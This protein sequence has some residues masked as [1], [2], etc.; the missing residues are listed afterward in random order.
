MNAD[1]YNIPLEGFVSANMRIVVFSGAGMSAESGLRTFRDN[2]GLWEEHSIYEVATPEA[3]ERDQ[4]LVLKFYNERRKQLLT[5]KPNAGHQALVKLEEHYDVHIVTQNIDDLH[6]RAGSSNVLHLH[7]ELR[8]ARSSGREDLVYEIEGWELKKGDCCDEGF[9]LRP[10]V[11]WFGEQVPMIP[12]AADIVA[13][14]DLLLVIGSSL[15]VYPAAGLVHAVR[16]GTPVIL[17]DPGN[18]EVS[19][20]PNLY[21]IQKPAADGVSALVDQL[22]QGPKA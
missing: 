7:G 4:D 8:K 22:L 18:P 13:T 14:A 6:E 9:Q 20:G 1:S 3:W 16:P 12:K 5:A 11:V 2:G 10:H 17:V 21:H 15:S 19:P